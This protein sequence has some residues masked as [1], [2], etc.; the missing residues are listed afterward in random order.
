VSRTITETSTQT[1]THT[2]TP[3][4]TLT[5]TETE[6]PTPTATI[7]HTPTETATVTHTPTETQTPTPTETTQPTPPPPSFSTYLYDG[8]GNMVRGSVKG[9]VTYY[10]GRHYHQQVDGE[11]ITVKKH[12][13]AGMQQIAVRTIVDEV[14][15]GVQW[16]LTDHLGSTSVVADEDGSL[17][18]QVKYTAFGEVRAATPCFSNFLQ[19]ML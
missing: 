16:I 1:A 6:T 19:S 5:P 14:D 10:A 4:I 8:D 11:S 2:H 15:E 9:V 3:T 17:V 13:Y 7:T 18:S 12:Y